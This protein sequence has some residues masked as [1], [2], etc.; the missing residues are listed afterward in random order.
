MAVV[1]KQPIP[2]S[3][4]MLSRAERET[5]D[6]LMTMSGLHRSEH[7]TGDDTGHIKNLKERLSLVEGE[8]MAGNNNDSLLTELHEILMRLHYFKVITVTQAR[9]HFGDI[10]KS[11]F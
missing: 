7:Y 3:L 8:I 5:Y 9:R 2:K 11:Y 10:K 4:K 6:L 1:K